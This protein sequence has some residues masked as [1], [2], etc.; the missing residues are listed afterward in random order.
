MIDR[1][2]ETRRLE[3]CIRGDVF[4]IILT[5]LVQLALLGEALGDG[6]AISWWIWA[7]AL[8]TCAL[9][10]LISGRRARRLSKRYRRLKWDEE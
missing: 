10:I 8:V 4:L 3:T 6:L 5:V 1:N 9:T 7:L 2:D